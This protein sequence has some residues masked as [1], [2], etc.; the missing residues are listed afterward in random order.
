M[1]I[2]LNTQTTKKKDEDGK[3]GKSGGGFTLVGDLLAHLK[4]LDLQQ[5]NLTRERNKGRGTV[6]QRK[7]PQPQHRK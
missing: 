2:D 5:K 7:K 4:E 3:G 1:Q 6:M